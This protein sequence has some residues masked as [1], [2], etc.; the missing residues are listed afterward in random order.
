MNIRELPENII[1]QLQ[2]IAEKNERSLEAEARYSYSAMVLSTKY[3]TRNTK[4]LISIRNI[5]TSLHSIE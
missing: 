3:S 4:C 5:E 2:K 1:E